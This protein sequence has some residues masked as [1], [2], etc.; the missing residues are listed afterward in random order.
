MAFLPQTQKWRGDRAVLL[1]HGVGDAKVGDYADLVRQLEEILGADAGRVAIYTFYYDQVNDWF[2][3]KVRAD[4]LFRQLLQALRGLLAQTP[5]ADSL[6]PTKLGNVASEFAGDVIWPVLIA[7]ARHAVQLS[8]IA[9]LQQ[10]VLDG[11]RAG[12]PPFNQKLSIIAHSLGCF[13][14]YEALH[15]VAADPTHGIGPATG[16][17]QFRNVLFMAS[18]VQ[19]IRSVAGALGAAVPQRET[20]RCLSQP[21]GMPLQSVDGRKIPS[22]R[23]TVSIAGNLD[24]VAGFFFRNRPDWSFTRLAAPDDIDAYSPRPELSIIVD[25]QQ[26][27]TVNGSEEPTLLAVLAQAL[28]TQSAPEITPNNPHSWSEYVRRHGS[29]LRQWLSA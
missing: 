6:D 14:T 19:L 27:A 4:L 1:V 15:S 2:A 23:R 5:L 22:A 12:V 26:L 16:G 28:R 7:D 8:L 10:I 29:E 18:P 20:L 21:I 24:P 17:V 3:T 13:H 9:Q 11:N 25:P